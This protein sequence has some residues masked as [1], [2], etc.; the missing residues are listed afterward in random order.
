ML[1]TR[2]PRHPTS[3]EEEAGVAGAAPPAAVKE[4][5]RWLVDTVLDSLAALGHLQLD[6]DSDIDH[7]PSLAATAVAT[8]LL[9][10]TG[11]IVERLSVAALD[12]AA[13]AAA[14]EMTGGSSGTS[15]GG[16]GNSGGGSSGGGGD[17]GS[18]AARHAVLL[19]ALWHAVAGSAS[20]SCPPSPGFTSAA[21]H[22]HV[23]AAA[24]D[25]V[26]GLPAVLRAIARL[27]GGCGGGGGRVPLLG[28]IM[29]AALTVKA[30]VE[31]HVAG[32]GPGARGRGVEDCV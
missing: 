21:S 14:A 20:A 1:L 29:A 31:R 8:A 4:D 23:A 24:C 28:D 26:G 30:G 3:L 18:V 10:L 12:S 15:N 6:A 17:G 16:G 19:L 32:L 5:R 9:S 7:I 11:R 27:G 13:A 25:T 2:Q 22:R